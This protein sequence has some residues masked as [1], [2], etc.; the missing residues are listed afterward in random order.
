[1]A[2]SEALVWRWGGAEVRI[3]SLGRGRKGNGAGS[4]SMLSEWS[5]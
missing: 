1:M 4:G 2:M 3:D 5:G